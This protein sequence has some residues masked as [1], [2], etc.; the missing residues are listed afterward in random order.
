M[1][2]IP[3]RRFSRTLG[4]LLILLVLVGLFALGAVLGYSARGRVDARAVPV[5]VTHDP[6][7][8]DRAVRLRLDALCADQAAKFWRGNSND[9]PRDG[10]INGYVN[11][12]NRGLGKCLILASSFTM[13]EGTMIET[14]YDAAEGIEIGTRVIEKAKT[15]IVRNG[16]PLVNG[17]NF[18]DTL[19]LRTWFDGLM[20]Q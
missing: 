3:P 15:T 7:D 10:S 12:F 14:V 18:G 17:V 1:T 16:Q 6:T 19:A 8:A 20:T 11:H 4:N 9:T 2:E 5:T 13:R